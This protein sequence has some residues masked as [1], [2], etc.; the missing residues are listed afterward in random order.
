MRALKLPGILL[1]MI[2]CLPQE[3]PNT[4]VIATA[5]NMQ[6]AMTELTEAFSDQSGIPCKTVISSSGKLTT[7]IKQGAPYDIFVSADVKYPMDLY[8]AG[9]AYSKP[10]TYAYGQ[11]IMWSQYPHLELKPETLL[12]P[13]VTHIAIANPQT[14]PYGQAAQVFLEKAGLW[15]RI[16]HKLVYGESISQTNQFILS[17]AAQ[18][19]FT[20]QSVLY[21][22]ETPKVAQWKYVDTGFYRPIAQSMV[23]LNNRPQMKQ[24]SQQFESFLFTRSAVTILK[25]YGYRVPQNEKF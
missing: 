15:T 8:D 19:G 17:E 6:F 20:G 7:Q 4:L 13:D 23:L 25:K 18:V 1:L 9:M 22:F 10:R 3:T 2:S 5:A 11:L 16:Q 12:R 24:A 21:A 14:A